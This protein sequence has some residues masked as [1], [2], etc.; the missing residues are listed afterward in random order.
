MD[1]MALFVLGNFEWYCRE[2]TFLPRPLPSNYD[3]LCPGFVLAEAEEYARDYEVS[4]LPQVVFLAMLLND[5]VK[6]D[7]LRGWM[8]G[9]MES[10][11]K[12]LRWS[13]FQAR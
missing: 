9:V 3:E 12:E 2:A 8:I 4:K 10:T 11:L 7:V 6:L 13:T 1:E 5:A